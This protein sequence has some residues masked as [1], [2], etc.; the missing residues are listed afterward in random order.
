MIISDLNHLET[1][2][3][4]PRVVGGSSHNSYFMSWP[5]SW[6]TNQSIK[7]A[8]VSQ[9]STSDGK[10]SAVAMAGKL[11]NGAYVAYASVSYASGY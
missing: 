6:L 7:K 8:V 5:Q 9:S 1:I 4:A 10:G 2:S 3:E 11:N